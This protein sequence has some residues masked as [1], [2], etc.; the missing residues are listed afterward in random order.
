MV[1]DT[2]GLSNE[3]NQKI[4]NGINYI[5]PFTSTDYD[6]KDILIVGSGTGNDVATAIRYS[7][8]N[9]DAVKIDPWLQI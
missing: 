3:I 9:I 1:T 8:A 6:F 2:I 5:I 7:N 4:Y